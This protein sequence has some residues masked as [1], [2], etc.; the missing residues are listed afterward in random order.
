MSN[1][2]RKVQIYHNISKTNRIILKVYKPSPHPLC[3]YMLY[4][5]KLS[6]RCRDEKIVFGSCPRYFH[7]SKKAFVGFRS[8][9]AIIFT[10]LEG[11]LKNAP[12]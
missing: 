12:L 2:W 9:S 3:R 5:V 11:R 7:L 8:T 1:L 4:M 10:L 6:E